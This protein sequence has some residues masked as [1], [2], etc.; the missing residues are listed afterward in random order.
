[1]CTRRVAGPIMVLEMCEE[2]LKNWLSQRSSLTTDDLEAFL[3]FSLNIAHGVEH[4]HSNKV[5]IDAR[6]HAR[7]ISLPYYFS[8]SY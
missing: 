4:L 8:D 7:C 2:S 3:G 5:G 6:T 1:M